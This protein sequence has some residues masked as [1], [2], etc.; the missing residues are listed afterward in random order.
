MGKHNKPAPPPEPPRDPPG[1]GDG[2]P[3]DVTKP[4]G[5]DHR[6]T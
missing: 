5:G 3:A 4:G 2:V 6:R 1:N